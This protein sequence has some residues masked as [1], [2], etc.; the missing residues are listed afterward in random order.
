MTVHSHLDPAMYLHYSF[1]SPSLFN[2][3]SNSIS[4]PLSTPYS[5]ASPSH[6][7]SA[8][9]FHALPHAN[10]NINTQDNKSMTN[11]SK[12]NKNPSL[13]SISN[14]AELLDTVLV[15]AITVLN[16]NGGPL[17]PTPIPTQKKNENTVKSN[18]I[19]RKITTRVVK[20]S[21][22]A[23]RII[24]LQHGLLILLFLITKS[25]CNGENDKFET[26]A[27]VMEI[28]IFDKKA[29][30]YFTN[31]CSCSIFDFFHLWCLCYNHCN[32]A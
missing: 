3:N 7:T 21:A 10:T 31:L 17:F 20:A 25:I 16:N 14:I 23:D 18:G 12:I 24:S 8:T 6:S 32:M 4:P 15:V 26:V 5:A 2:S 29:S 22:L 19:S 28:F 27:Q 13:I 30:L 11:S 1:L 9:T